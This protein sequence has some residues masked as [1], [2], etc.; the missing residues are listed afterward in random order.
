MGMEL[1]ISEALFASWNGGL[2]SSATSFG[3]VI[4]PFAEFRFAYRVG[5]E[6]IDIVQHFHSLSSQPT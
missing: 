4:Q 2:K 3:K 6:G 1:G 5:M